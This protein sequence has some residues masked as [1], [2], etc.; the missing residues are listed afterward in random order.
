M[1]SVEYLLSFISIMA[2]LGLIV[3]CCVV[4][5]NAVEHLGRYHNLGDGAT[6]CILAAIGTALPETIVPLV[7]IFGAYIAGESIQVGNEI[8]IGA[9]LGSPFL[10][11][12][13]AMLVTG[14]AVFIFTKLKAREM[15]INVD[16]KLLHRDLRFFLISYTVAVL[17]T[18]IKVALLKYIVGIGLL[19]FYLVYVFRTINKCCDGVC[20]TEI[21]ELYLSKLFKIKD[22]L[23]IILI[24][25]QILISI[26]CLIY[27]S[28][29]FVENIKFVASSFNVAPLLIS[30]LLAPIATELPEMFNSVIWMGKSKDTLA[31]S[32]ITG[33][34]VF[35]S[36]IPMSIGLFFTTW[37]FS[38][39]AII[40][41]ILVYI[42]VIILYISVIK[43]ENKLNAKTLI[44]SGLFY[45]I[46]LGY[47]FVR[48]LG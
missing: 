34:M 21:E 12:T 47:V 11:C 8:G 16:T 41:I 18:F 3:G 26:L 6:G 30:L 40:N 15:E 7:A 2:L 14:I 10:L 23:Q 38:S 27:F 17:S 22:K 28:H 33:A 46:Y 35:Q 1:I 31:M 25:A 5:T 37:K 24:W 48:I 4:F 44:I 36:C 45:I 43:S 20:E 9:I 13:L 19:V 39:E 29:L 32:N 42:A